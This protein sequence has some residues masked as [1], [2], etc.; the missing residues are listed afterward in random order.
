VAA[1]GHGADEIHELHQAAAEKGA[2]GVGVGGED[3][4]AAFGLGGADGTGTGAIGH[5][6]IVIAGDCIWRGCAAS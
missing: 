4:L 1:G 6:S 5:S 2:E 3:D